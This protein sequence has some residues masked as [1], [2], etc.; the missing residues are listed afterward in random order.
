MRRVFIGV[1][2][3]QWLAYT[4]AAHSV[5][6]RSSVPVAVIPL[7][8]SQLPLKRKGLTEFTFTRYLVPYLCEY[9]GK[10]L[11]LDA[12]TLALADIE[13]LPWDNPEAVSVV[14]HDKVIVKGRE[15]KVRFERPSVMLFNCEKCT[16]LTPDYIETGAPQSFEWAGSVG[17]LPPEWN[18]LVGYDAPGVA[19]LVHFTQGIPCFEETRADE[20]AREWTDTLAALQG[21][22]SWAEIMGNSVHAQ[23]KTNPLKGYFSPFAKVAL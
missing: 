15:V 1:D 6:S 11:F 23:F 3:R 12:D 18:H 10:A 8:Y 2:P 9:Q 13:T 20:Y 17:V 16:R 7:V 5:V 4:V 21:T 19:K 22:C 14:P